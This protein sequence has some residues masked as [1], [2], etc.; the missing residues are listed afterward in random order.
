MVGVAGK[1]HSLEIS[2]LGCQTHQKR[3][4]E[5][6]G[7]S[8]RL[9]NRRKRGSGSDPDQLDLFRPPTE[10]PPVRQHGG[11]NNRP[12]EWKRQTVEGQNTPP[13]PVNNATGPGWFAAVRTDRRLPLSAVSLARVIAEGRPLS[14]VELAAAT[15]FS[16]RMVPLAAAR[17]ERAGWVVRLR[18]GGRRR[19]TRFVPTVPGGTA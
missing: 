14:A 18:G 2:A 11:A 15:G 9:S 19:K 5:G 8:G 10:S 7:L 1:G 17:L 6:K 12:P 4:I 3:T 16:L 13:A